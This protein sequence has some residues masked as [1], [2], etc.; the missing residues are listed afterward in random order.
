MDGQRNAY[1]VDLA[2]SYE[3][4]VRSFVHRGLRVGEHST[5]TIHHRG[6]QCL[7]LYYVLTRLDVTELDRPSTAWQK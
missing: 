3:N 2:A 6:L 5:S 1:I 4:N 7:V